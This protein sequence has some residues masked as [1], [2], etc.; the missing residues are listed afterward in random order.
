MRPATTSP[1]S[2]LLVSLL[3]LHASVPLPAARAAVSSDACPR[4][5][6]RPQ[7]H[8]RPPSGVLSDICGTIYLDNSNNSHGAEDHGDNSRDDTRDSSEGNSKTS[9]HGSNCSSDTSSHC[10]SDNNSHT[11]TQNTKASDVH[12]FTAAA[13]AAHAGHRAAGP[14]PGGR[15]HLFHQHNEPT[16]GETAM[17]WYHLSSPDLVSWRQEGVALLPNETYSAHGAW[18]G[19][20]SV[21]GGRVRL[22]Y[23]CLPANGSNMLCAATPTDASLTGFVEYAGNPVVR[24]APPGSNMF[25]FRDPTAMFLPPGAAPGAAWREDGAR[26]EWGPTVGERRRARPWPSGARAA[27]D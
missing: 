2:S 15:Y 14:T 19:S 16:R 18:D 8:A 20:L 17:R 3:L 6:L 4:E 13:A 12:P 22:L 7:W 1:F 26:R 10:S 24:D 9:S 25:D 23:S 5:A 21:I 11:S 27:C